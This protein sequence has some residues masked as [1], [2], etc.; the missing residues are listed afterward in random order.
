MQSSDRLSPMA[1][2][3]QA[4][5]ANS[6]EITNKERN[7]APINWTNMILFTVTPALAA[8]LVPAYGW[9]VGFDAFEWSMFATMMVF[10]GMS[11]TAGY[12]RLWSHKTYEAHSSVRFLFA[13][14]GAFALQNDVL[15]W[16]SDHRRHHRNNHGP[17]RRRTRGSTESRG[18]D[19]PTLA[20]ID[21]ELG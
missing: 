8:T 2:G 10:C 15:N 16:A 21:D 13:L 14:G 9:I 4:Q 3:Q 18:C 17:P 11:I 20:I 1:Q 12:H 7:K 6:A 19:R 5:P